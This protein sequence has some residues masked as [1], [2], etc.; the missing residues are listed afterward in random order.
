MF[1]EFIGFVGFIEFVEFI[2]LI[3]DRGQDRLIVVPHTETQGT[4]RGRNKEYRSQKTP[5]E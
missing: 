5:E 4:Q 2:G 1:V 3:K